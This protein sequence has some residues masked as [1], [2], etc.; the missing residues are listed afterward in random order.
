M[1]I[2]TLLRG[3]KDPTYL[4]ERVGYRLYE[5]MHPD[6]PWLSQDAIRFC[7]SRLN[8]EMVGFEWGS[9]RSTAWFAKRLKHL[10]TIEH[11]KGWYLKV[12]E[13]LRN[14]GITNVDYRFVPLD[15]D[16]SAPTVPYYEVTPAY[17]AVIKEF[18]DCFFDL[19]VVDGHYRQAC[20]LASLSKLKP[21]GLLLLDNTNWLPLSE[22]NIPPGWPLLHQ[23]SNVMTQT[24]IWSKSER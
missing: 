17:V 10:Y 5:L 15:H 6:E 23:S 19:V 14:S 9:G 8:S 20:V 22:W 12:S 16:A 21:G 2:R 13:G 3:L 24:S 18:V 4:L 1:Q 7:A 11:D